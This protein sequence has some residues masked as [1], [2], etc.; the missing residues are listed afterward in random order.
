[1][2]KFVDHTGKRFGYLVALRKESRDSKH[3]K[4]AYWYCRCD[5]GNEKWISANNLTRGNCISCGCK[6]EEHLN[7]KINPLKRDNPRIYRIWSGMKIRCFC[8]NSSRYADYGGRGIT[9]CDEWMV[10]DNFC[11]WALSNGYEDGLT[12]ERLNNDKS[13]CPDNCT[14]I[15]LEEQ[16]KN[17]RNLRIYTYKGQTMHLAAWARLYNMS[18]SLLYDRLDSGM[19]FEDAITI[20]VGMVRQ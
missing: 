14:W 3:G 20:P 15:K 17:K 10:F 5:C 11:L 19:S 6:Q 1:M 13:Y 7:H 9:I 8:K 2:P 4:V 12:I 18:Y 16:V